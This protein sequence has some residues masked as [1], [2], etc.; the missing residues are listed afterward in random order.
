MSLLI[1]QIV[2]AVLGLAATLFTW[3]VKRDSDKKKVVDDED[4]KIDAAKSFDDFVRIDD[5]LRGK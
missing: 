3:W 2:L 1:L 5:E 4:K